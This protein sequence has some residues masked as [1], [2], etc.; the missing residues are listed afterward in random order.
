VAAWSC[1][2]SARATFPAVCST[3]SP[4]RTPSTFKNRIKKDEKALKVNPNNT[5]A[6]ADLVR[7]R[8][9]LA[10]DDTDAT[11]GAF[12]PDGKAELAKA[13][14]AWQ[15]YLKAADK[16][17][18]SLAGLMLQA[19]GPSAL[20]K[21]DQAAGAA[22]LIANARPSPQAYLTLMTYAQQAGQTR[23]AT[24]AGQKAIEL[25]P[26]SQRKLVKQQVEAAKASAGAAATSQ[27]SG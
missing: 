15:R 4:V 18:D 27:G 21:P 23:K 19:Y 25:A 16:P 20:N 10:T 24:L 22:E 5:A 6:L 2:G 13:D 9:Q 12:G 14:L 11:T 17:S 8:Y 26:K 3:P 1:S 7:T